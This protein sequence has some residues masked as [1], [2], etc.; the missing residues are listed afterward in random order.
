MIRESTHGLTDAA[1]TMEEITDPGEL[2]GAH[3]QDVRFQRNLAWLEAHAAQVYAQHR[4]KCICVSGEELF[5]ADT[6]AAVLALAVAAHPADDGR[7]TRY[8]PRENTTR[9]Y[10]HYRPLAPGG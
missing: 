8:I 2:A 9:I 5:V 4:G 1:V 7:F 6:P 10:T 3:A